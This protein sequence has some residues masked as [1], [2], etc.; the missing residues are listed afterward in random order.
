MSDQQSSVL[1]EA[2]EAAKEHGGGERGELVAIETW[3]RAPT[4]SAD[5][6]KYWENEEVP[7]RLRTIIEN[8]SR[9]PAE[10]KQGADWGKG[11]GARVPSQGWDVR[12]IGGNRTFTEGSDTFGALTWD[13]VH[14]QQLRANAPGVTNSPAPKAA[15]PKEGL[16]KDWGRSGWGD[17]PSAPTRG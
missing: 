6:K 3:M 2:L 13:Q 12:P 17:D 7:Q 16:W 14:Q 4:G 1:Q 9:E 5:W 15:P 11:N 10:L 8:A